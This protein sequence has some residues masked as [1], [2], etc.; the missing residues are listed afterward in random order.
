MAK[1]VI[2]ISADITHGQFDRHFVYEHYLDA[3]EHAGGVPVILPPL[4]RPERVYRQLEV[5]DGFFG[6]GS[7]DFDPGLF[8]EDRHPHTRLMPRR[9]QEHDLVLL[10]LVWNMRL[11]SLMVCGSMQGLNLVLGGD[12]DQHID[13]E[14][15]HKHMDGLEFAHPIKINKT[16]RLAKVTGRH[17]L[18]VNSLH[19]QAVR[20]VPEGLVVVAEASDGVIE[21]LEPVDEA[22]P[23]LAVQWHPE[24]MAHTDDARAIFEWSIDESIRSRPLPISDKE[25]VRLSPFI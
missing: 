17:K 24:R 22:H 4:M 9:R 21:A 12:L 6:I 20:I 16:S 3:I 14:T 18:D 25:V 23:L 19:H 13:S 1:P 8:G 11:P 10:N 5:L 15:S 2:G 7:D